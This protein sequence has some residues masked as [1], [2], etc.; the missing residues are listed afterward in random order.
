MGLPTPEVQPDPLKTTTVIVGLPW[1]TGPDDDTFPQYFDFMMYLGSLAERT[2]IR[3]LLGAEAFDGLA[4]PPLCPGDPLAEPTVADYERMGRLRIAICNYSRTSLVGKAREHIA[5]S[6]LHEDADYILWWDDDMRF[7]YST[8]L[9]LWRNDL[10]IVGALAFTAREPI[11]PVI[12][13]AEKINSPDGAVVEQSSPLF[14]YP[15]DTLVG[16][17]HVPGWLAF[18]A[19]M[20]LTAVDVFRQIPQPWFASTGCGEDFHFC[21]RAAE[22]GVPRF[23]DTRIKVQHKHHTA[24][25]CDE[26]VYWWTREH[27]PEAYE[28]S[29]NRLNDVKDGVVVR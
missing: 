8:F 12:F 16:D 2:Q 4:L 26:N 19:G 27:R 28:E 3:Q 29:W 25:W 22:Y 13:G 5:Q 24:R 21:S 20:M 7:E 17:E 11:Y 23:V 15:R 10:P 18:G 14:D 6:A 1:Y 9:R